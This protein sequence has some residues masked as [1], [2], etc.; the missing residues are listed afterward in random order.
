MQRPW[1]VLLTP[2]VCSTCFLYIFLNRNVFL[3]EPL[4]FLF[5]YYVCN[6]LSVC[7]P[8]GQKR[9]PDLITDGCEPPC[10][11][12]ELNSGPLEE[13]TMLLTTEPSLQLLNLLSYRQPKD[14]IIQWIGPSPIDH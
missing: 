1:R 11:C 2:M 3:R 5:I 12:W 14:G 9:A 8:S 4:F 13:T 7:I 10:G 6:I